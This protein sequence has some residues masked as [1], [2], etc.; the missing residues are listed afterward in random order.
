MR[1]SEG[2]CCGVRTLAFRIERRGRPRDERMEFTPWV[3]ME[4]LER[5]KEVFDILVWKREHFPNVV[6]M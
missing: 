2:F 5:G 4:S 6:F 1:D 3:E